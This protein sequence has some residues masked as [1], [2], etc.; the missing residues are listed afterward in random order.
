[1]DDP[2]QRAAGQLG[3]YGTMV[4]LGERPF[5]EIVSDIVGHAREIVRSEVR[6]DAGG[7]RGAWSDRAGIFPLDGGLRPSHWSFPCGHRC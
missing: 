3:E 4:R 6:L 1:M 7:R 2:G 5:S